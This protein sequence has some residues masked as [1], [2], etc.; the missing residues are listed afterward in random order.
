[1]NSRHLEDP[2][3]LLEKDQDFQ[4]KPDTIILLANMTAS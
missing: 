2:S 3:G 4:Y 1:M